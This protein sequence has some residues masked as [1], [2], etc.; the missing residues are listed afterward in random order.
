WPKVQGIQAQLEILFF[1]IN[2]T[3][4]VLTRNSKSRRI[5]ILFRAKYYINT[6]EYAIVDAPYVYYDDF[7]CN[8]KNLHNFCISCI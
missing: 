8:T 7:K 4:P 2:V 3:V 6:K 1:E 5:Q